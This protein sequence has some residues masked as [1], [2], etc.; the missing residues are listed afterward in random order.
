MTCRRIWRFGIGAMALGALAVLTPAARAQQSGHGAAAPA[1][2]PPAPRTYTMEELH[3]S[4]GTP[5]GWKFTLPAGDPAKGR[6]VFRELECFK[7]HTLKGENFPPAGGDGKAGPELT[8][9]G[10]QHP[11]EYMA[12]SILAPNAVIVDGP[13]FT[14]PDGRSIMPSFADS[15]SATQLLDLVAFLKSQTDPAGAREHGGAPAEQVVGDYRVRLEYKNGDHGGHGGHAAGGGAG[16]LMVFVSDR[17]S[18][19][20]VPYLPVTATLRSAGKPARVVRLA[21]MVGGQGF[22]YGASVALPEGTQKIALA[23][24]RTTMQVMDAAKGRFTKPVTVVF[25]WGPHGGK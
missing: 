19:E 13:G 14:G 16:H 9:M 3:K 11:A 17:E 22:H 20:P 21:P 1:P 12:E 24:G 2:A 23:I 18:G 7:C 15:L 4:G 25:D 8:G 10:S 6:E 5:R